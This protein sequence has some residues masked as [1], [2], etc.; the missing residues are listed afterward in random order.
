MSGVQFHETRRGV[1]FYERDVPRL[2]EALQEI[3]AELKALNAALRRE[4]ASGDGP[5][6]ENA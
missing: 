1:T 3:A 5:S 6:E 2:V 4:E